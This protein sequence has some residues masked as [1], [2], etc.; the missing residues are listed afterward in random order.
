L[1]FLATTAASVPAE[2]AG[3]SGSYTLQPLVEKAPEAIAAALRTT[4]HES[5]QRV[6][7]E[8][9]QPYADLWLRKSV[10][11]IKSAPEVGIA[12]GN[13]EEG[14]FV[15][16]VRFHQ[17]SKDFKGKSFKEGTYTLRRGVQPQDG[18]HLGVSDSRDFLLLS[19]ASA[20]TEL[21]SLPTKDLVK[22]S[23]KASGSKHP[24]ILYLMKPPEIPKDLPKLIADEDRG[25]WVLTCSVEASG[26]EKT[27]LVLGIVLIGQ[28]AEF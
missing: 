18:D 8:K 19:P 15:G 20:D 13:V 3:S 27:P 16:V 11:T 1:S 23:V 14:A 10:P 28:S 12:Y 24:S 7:D 21:P 6:L 17:G 26:A 5:G 2:A 4:L 22:L 25:F 9:G